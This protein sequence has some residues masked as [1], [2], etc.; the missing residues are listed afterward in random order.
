MEIK[1][2]GMKFLILLMAITNI[3]TRYESCSKNTKGIG[4]DNILVWSYK[5]KL[6]WKDF[7]GKK[8]PNSKYA[9][10]SAI[11]LKLDYTL[12]DYFFDKFNVYCLFFKNDSWAL[13]STDYGLNH[14]QK[15]FDV[16]EV[17]ARL[18]RK[19]LISINKKIK[20]ITPKIMD[21]IYKIVYK[22]MDNMQTEYDEQ[23]GRSLYYDG[24]EKWDA[25]IQSMLDSLKEY[26]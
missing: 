10:V 20:I 13:D 19:E 16:G 5:R 1:Y 7:I 15:H 23:T 3:A 25:K 22:N 18:L 4:N 21:S 17:Q 14:E 2:I 26:K 9:A 11:T 24:Q 8:E 6:V 12:K